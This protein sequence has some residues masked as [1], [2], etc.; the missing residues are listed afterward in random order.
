MAPAPAC[1]LHPTRRQ[2]LLLV[3]AALAWHA[4]IWLGTRPAR[5]AQV[6]AAV[7]RQVL[8]PVLRL[9]G[10]AMP[11]PAQRAAAPSGQAAARPAVVI[12]RPLVSS[13]LQPAGLPAEPGTAAPVRRPA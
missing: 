7:P 6:P 8:R 10:G 5:D 3:A 1:P 2:W 9:V 4:L 11:G 13:E 12:L